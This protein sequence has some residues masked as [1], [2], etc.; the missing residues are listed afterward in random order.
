MSDQVIRDIRVS[1]QGNQQVALT[2]GMDKRLT[3]TS[4]DSSAPLHSFLLPVPVW[5][6]EW[7]QDD[8]NCFFAGLSNGTVLS[9][10]MRHLASPLSVFNGTPGPS[11]HSLYSHRS[12]LYAATATDVRCYANVLQADSHMTQL[13]FPQAQGY[14]CSS[15]SFDASSDTHLA[16]F[17][18]QQA[19]SK[20][21]SFR[22]NDQIV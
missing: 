15:L 21:I 22:V 2:A 20:Y 10:D 9:F 12:S 19:P 5:S 16:C 18:S 14:F 17:R 3:L 1:L 13:K 7:S 8:S 6:C 4:L 11:V